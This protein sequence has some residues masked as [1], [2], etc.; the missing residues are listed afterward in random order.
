MKNKAQRETNLKFYNVMAEPTLM[1]GCETWTLL[2]KDIQKIQAS[3]MKL[4]RAVKG[5]S[6]R[7]HLRNDDIRKDLKLQS[8]L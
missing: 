8:V 4:L 6:F 5:C 1:Y 2:Q 3:E 7:D